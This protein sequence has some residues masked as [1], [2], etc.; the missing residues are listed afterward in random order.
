MYAGSAS[1]L[2]FLSLLLS[3]LVKLPR[4]K[5]DSP[6][7]WSRAEDCV[8]S[9]EGRCAGCRTELWRPVPAVQCFRWSGGG[10][11]TALF[12]RAGTSLRGGDDPPSGPLLGPPL[13]PLP[14]IRTAILAAGSPT[15]ANVALI[16]SAYLNLTQCR[17]FAV[18]TNPSTAQLGRSYH[19][20]NVIHDET[21][22]CCWDDLKII[23]QLMLLG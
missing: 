8:L 2:E 4:E 3:L 9:T 6:E 17:R 5:E 18:T 20:S 7:G 16:L 12:R 23:N 21:S 14:P 13:A 11:R 1:L 22:S 15:W 19:R 10:E